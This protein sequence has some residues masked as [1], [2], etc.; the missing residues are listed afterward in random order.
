MEEGL[1]NYVRSNKEKVR[2]LKNALNVSRLKNL[3][4]PD[5]LSFQKTASAYE[6]TQAIMAKN[7]WMTVGFQKARKLEGIQ[8]FHES[9]LKESLK[10]IRSFTFE[11]AESFLPRIEAALKNSGV[12]FVFLRYLKNSNINGAV[13]W[14]DDDSAV[15]I[16]SDRKQYLDT[17][18]FA[19][20]HEMGHVLQK[21]KRK[22]IISG[23]ERNALEEDADAFAKDML[24]DPDAYHTFVNGKLFTRKD[25]MEFSHAQ[26]IHPGI[27]VGRLQKE[28]YIPHSWHN[29]I[30]I[31]FGS[32]ST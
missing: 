21:R 25:I 15:V 26:K 29:N 30:R 13:K 31:K 2:Q 14:F 28:G 12:R 32:D 19:F 11:T 9:K 4:K 17:F 22:I 7:A 20:Y 24:I 27:V 18:W 6:P 10:K 3:E 8:P 23:A 16:L 1:V 5:L